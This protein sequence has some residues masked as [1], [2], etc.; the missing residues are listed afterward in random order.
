MKFKE[1]CRKCLMIAICSVKYSMNQD[2]I[3][4]SKCM[5]GNGVGHDCMIEHVFLM[6]SSL[7]D[8]CKTFLCTCTIYN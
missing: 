4:G 2:G 8:A 5:G 3:G 1:C 6:Q 7:F